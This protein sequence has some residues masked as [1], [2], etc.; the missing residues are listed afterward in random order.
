MTFRDQSIAK[1]KINNLFFK[2]Q[3]SSNQGNVYSNWPHVPSWG[4]NTSIAVPSDNNIPGFNNR[5]DQNQ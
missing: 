3:M 4:I 1:H 2:I 5:I